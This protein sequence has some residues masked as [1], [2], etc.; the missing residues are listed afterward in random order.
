MLFCKR[1]TITSPQNNIY[2][3]DDNDSIEYILGDSW[4]EYAKIY[5]ISDSLEKI[6][7][8][9]NIKS[10]VMCYG[11][12]GETSKNIYSNLSKRPT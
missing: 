12:P 10:E 6:L 1:T 7:L 9:N 2:T 4:A 8:R 11:L 5:N 3:K